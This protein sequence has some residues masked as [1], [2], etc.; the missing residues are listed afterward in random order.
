MPF[1]LPFPVLLAL[2]GALYWP[3]TLSVAI[4]LTVLGALAPWR[5]VKV[6]CFGLACILA[7]DC[8]LAL[9]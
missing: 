1:N 3:I 6:V 4:A 8:L 5:W 2:A 7:A 9:A